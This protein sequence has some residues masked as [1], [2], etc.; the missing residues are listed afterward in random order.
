MEII[1][2]S[3][4]GHSTNTTN[5]EQIIVEG[6]SSTESESFAQK[7]GLQRNCGNKK[8]FVFEFIHPFNKKTF[9]N[10]GEQEKLFAE[11]V[12]AIQRELPATQRNNITVIKTTVTKKDGEKVKTVRLLASPQMEESIQ[13]LKI[14]TLMSEIVISAYGDKNAQP[15]RLSMRN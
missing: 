6:N 1:T 12:S 5:A 13:K 3:E 4:T 7:N 15:E 14:K 10:P 11:I 9:A 2:D 8:P